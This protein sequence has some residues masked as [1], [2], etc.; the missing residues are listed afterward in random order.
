MGSKGSIADFKS[1][2][3]NINQRIE[4]IGLCSERQKHSEKPIEVYGIIKKIFNIALLDGIELF[5]RK[6][7]PENNFLDLYG[8]SLPGHFDEAAIE[9]GAD[10]Y[11]NKV[12]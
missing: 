8:D 9:H 3:L 12:N 1:P 6:R 7:V 11:G 5:S 4:T 10:V 2:L